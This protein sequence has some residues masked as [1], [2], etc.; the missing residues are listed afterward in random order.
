MSQ[1]QAP[2]LR[3][4][5]LVALGGNAPSDAGG[6]QETV[7]AAV[8]ALGDIFGD[9]RISKLYQT[10]AFPAGS[11]PNFINAACSFLTDMPSADLLAT[12][13]S[14]EADFGRERVERW[15]QRTLDLDLIA[16]G[17]VVLPDLATFN[18]WRNLPPEDQ[19]V[20]APDTLILP[21]PRVQ[22]R[23]F[24]LVPM[25]DIAPNWVHPVLGQTTAEML[26][27]LSALQRDEIL[28][29]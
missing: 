23:A 7:L 1:A 19:K 5:A 17:D 20:Q 16:F 10:P 15:G 13:H 4:N 2:S 27:G 8:A 11:G 9:V 14:I 21:H 24:V 12:F 28:A 22:D 3:N 18:R 26:A 29:L 6:P 25:A